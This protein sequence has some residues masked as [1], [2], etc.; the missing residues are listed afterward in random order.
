M[1][2]RFVVSPQIGP[3]RL[4]VKM[5]RLIKVRLNTARVLG[6][7][8]HSTRN[9]PGLFCVADGSSAGSDGSSKHRRAAQGVVAMVIHKRRRLK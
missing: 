5:A 6:H 7:P 8:N 2:F 3:S 4:L 1:I 9:S